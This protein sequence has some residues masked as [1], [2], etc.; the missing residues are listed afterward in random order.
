MSSFTVQTS[1]MSVRKDRSE[2]TD[3]GD[4]TLLREKLD[5]SCF[6]GWNVRAD[7]AVLQLYIETDAPEVRK[8]A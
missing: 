7:G 6:K 4:H 1:E 2:F 5:E 8:P 3:Q